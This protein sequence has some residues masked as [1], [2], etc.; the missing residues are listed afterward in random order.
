MKNPFEGKKFRVTQTQ[1]GI[2]GKYSENHQA[3]D[4]V[5][6][7]N[8]NIVATED[9]EV[10]SSQIVTDK[11]NLSWTYGNY[12]K[13][14]LKDGT[15]ILVAHLSK[16]LVKKGDKIKKG[17]V[18]G[19][20]GSTGRSTAAHLHIEHRAADGSTRLKVYDYLGIKN[21]KGEAKEA[22][23]EPE[24]KPAA[25]P[26]TNTATKIKEGDVVRIKP[27]ASYTNGVKVPEMYIGKDF[28]VRQH[29]DKLARTLI[30]ELNSWVYDKYIETTGKKTPAKIVVNSRVEISKGAVYAN[31]VKVPS[32]CIGV[33]Y[34][35]M[36][37]YANKA[38]LREI[39]SWVSMKYLKLI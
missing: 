17:Q 20:M 9:G 38:L 6:D 8:Y 31:G 37:T 18:I 16:R 5:C 32:E 29:D 35:V 19:V 3:M 1:H 25:K 30:K 26:T 28:T 23:Q 34:T 22:A 24:T 15:Y 33:P 11:N 12:I 7:E 14:R 13:Y 39:M 21:E 4:L 27:G 36:Q 10:T 2:E